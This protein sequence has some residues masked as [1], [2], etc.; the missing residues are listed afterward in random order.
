MVYPP[1]VFEFSCLVKR[2]NVKKQEIGCQAAGIMVIY[3]RAKSLF[4]PV[5][6]VFYFAA[7]PSTRMAGRALP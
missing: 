2:F 6:P 7:V 4:G 1:Q 5:I 3:L